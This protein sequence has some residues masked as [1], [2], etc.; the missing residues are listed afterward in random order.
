MTDKTTP[1]ILIV[2]LVGL[3][4]GSDGRPDHSAVKAHIEARGGTFHEGSARSL[5]TPE[6]GR[7]H[8]YYQ[9][10]LSTEAELLAEAG[11]GLYDAVIAAATFL[12]KDTRFD[13]GGVRIGS[14]TGNMGS[15]SWGGGD[16][17][18]G[19]APLMNTPGINAGA[20]A[21]MVM[22][23][24]LRVR[25]DLP[26]DEMN[27]LVA[28]GRFDTG[29]DLVRFPT[30]KLEGRIF[31]IVGYGNIGREV[32]KIARA[33]GM[34]V[35]VHARS[36]HRKWIESEG[37]Q[38]AATLRDAAADADVLSVHIG[39]GPLGANGYANARL[40]GD[41]VLSALAIGAVVINYD[42]GELIDVPALS[43]ALSSGRV[44]HAAIDADLFQDTE[45]GILSGP[46]VPYLSLLPMHA[47]RMSLLPH[48]AADTDHPTRVSGALQAVDQILD[49]I[50]T[51]VTRNLKGDLP[52]G[53]TDA[54]INSPIGTGASQLEA[55]RLDAARISALRTSAQAFLSALD[56][57][58]EEGPA[59]TGEQL[60]LDSNRLATV[61]RSES[62]DGPY[63]NRA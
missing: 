60:L 22:K 13:L 8:F 15:A 52:A 63:R 47:E 58:I 17:R 40:I 27:A 50:Q 53:Y 4:P 43:A 62:L 51:G 46:M 37:F 25:P 12:P 20:T 59:L 6:V 41:E 49:A 31:A 9:P 14:G 42:R 39:L 10:M 30:S 18:G 44:A 7:P 19:H 11:D 21:Q 48:A 34:T 29:R 54:G 36:H 38:Y 61:L 23:A 2:D 26:V 5:P 16:G 28:A 56:R 35:R 3:A 33:F 24:L 57:L 1:K 55:L 45:K 32:A